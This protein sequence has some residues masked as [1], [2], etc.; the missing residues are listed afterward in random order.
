MFIK[1]SFLYFF[2][3]VWVYK[4]ICIMSILISFFLSLFSSIFYGLLTTLIYTKI[5]TL[6]SRETHRRALTSLFPR[7]LVIPSSSMHLPLLL[8][9][10]VCS[11]WIA[12]L[13]TSGV[14]SSWVD[15]TL[16]PESVVWEIGNLVVF[17]NK[18]SLCLIGLY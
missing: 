18:V 16:F 7:I 1:A 6:P 11:D 12:Y 5:P 2:Y 9:N 13:G 14:R 10:Y 17:L 4:S 15:H 8:T 3:I